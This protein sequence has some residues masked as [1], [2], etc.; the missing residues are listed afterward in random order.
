QA[1]CAASASCAI[2]PV[3]RRFR[4]ARL[5]YLASRSERLLYNTPARL[6]H[7]L[8]S[9][10]YSTLKHLAWIHDAVRVESPLELAHQLQLQR[11]LVAPDFIAFQLTEPMLGADR[12][13]ETRHA[14]VHQAI[15]RRRILGKN[16]RGNPFGSRY[17][18]V[19]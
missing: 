14:V 3:S 17:V 11:R 15:D 16:I 1:S 10:D 18:V 13:A 7:R 19:K 2:A 6:V 8:P 4:R 12:A 9:Y 5:T